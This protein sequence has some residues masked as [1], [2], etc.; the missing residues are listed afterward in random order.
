MYDINAISLTNQTLF[1]QMVAEILA[2]QQ[3]GSHL[4]EAVVIRKAVISRIKA[5]RS[6]EE[7]PRPLSP[8]NPHSPPSASQYAKPNLKPASERAQKTKATGVSLPGHRVRQSR[9][10]SGCR[11]VCQAGHSNFSHIAGDRTEK[12]LVMIPSSGTV[13]R[14]VLNIAMLS[15]L[16][17]SLISS[18]LALVRF[19]EM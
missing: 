9:A 16:S 1:Y 19:S 3:K 12:N 18:L 5:W 8:P 13:G 10:K 2:E 6:G 4:V 7:M 17:P 11:H 14:L 15:V